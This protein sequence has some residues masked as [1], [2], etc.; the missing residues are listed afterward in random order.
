MAG[1]S[2]FASLLAGTQ[3][4]Q[5]IAGSPDSYNE[6]SNPRFVTLENKERID[7]V[8]FDKHFNDFNFSDPPIE[9]VH[10][11]NQLTSFLKMKLQRKKHEKLLKKQQAA[12]VEHEKPRQ[13]CSK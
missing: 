10:I 11:L 4:G 9:E 2:L 1:S 12:L 6:V 7:M 8:E 3:D 13:P 5:I